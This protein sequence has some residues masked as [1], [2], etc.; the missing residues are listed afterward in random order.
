LG[1]N[2]S[3]ELFYK[4]I[5]NAGGW[6]NDVELVKSFIDSQLDTYHWLG[7][8]GVEFYKV[9]IGAAMSVPRA[10]VTRIG[11]AVGVLKG[12]AEQK[13]VQ[14]GFETMAGRLIEDE[15][16]SVVGI[17]VKGKYGHGF[18]KAK[19]GVVLATGGFGY[20][21]KM[22]SLVGVDLSKIINMVSKSHTGDG[23][24]MALE[25]GA[26][27]RDLAYVQPTFGAHMNARTT[28]DALFAN[29]LEAIIVNR[30][31]K[32]FVN[33]SMAYKEIGAKALMQPE[34]VGIMVFDDKICEK[35]QQHVFRMT[36]RIKSLCKLA[37]TIDGLAV[38]LGIGA[39]TLEETIE[40]YNLYVEARNDIEFGRKGLVGSSGD[41]VKLDTPPF[42][43]FEAVGALVGT[44]G[45]ITVDNKMRVTNFFDE[46]IPGLYAAGE[47]IGGFHGAG[48]MTGTA[49]GK[50]F[51]FGRT[52][53][54]EASR[55]KL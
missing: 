43:G 28:H 3:S 20:W 17:E 41:L 22:I 29:Y 21:D 18:M 13:G 10:H 2:D 12:V 26:G 47:I 35:V 51:V 15:M 33:E 54:R 11:G 40:K 42:Y 25:L 1:I 31:G 32:R 39:S 36:P 53:G 46:I 7:E 45:G 27:L 30:L 8:A 9:D 50:A 34:G 37:E 24:K 5:M 6:K 14:F 4:E 16:G 52:A 23:H 38:S 44:Y 48:Y 19:R 55:E 49:L